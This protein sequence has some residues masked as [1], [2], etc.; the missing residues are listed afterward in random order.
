[1]MPTGKAGVESPDLEEEAGVGLEAVESG[2]E[3]GR[4]GALFLTSSS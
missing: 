1:M 3:L 4:G 2:T